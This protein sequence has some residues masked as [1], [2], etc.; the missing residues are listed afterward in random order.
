M[1]AK[2]KR[3][4]LCAAAAVLLF[5]LACSAQVT[6]SPTPEPAPTG[7][8]YTV[9]SITTIN[10]PYV[11]SMDWS[12]T[13]NL[14]AFGKLDLQDRYYDVYVM[15]PDGTNEKCLTCGKP[16][17][18]QKHNGNPAWHP[19]GDYIVFTAENPDNPVE[20][21]R[22]AVP[23][24]GFHCA[25][26]LM[27]SD[28]K[29]F[30]QL[31][32]YSTERPIK[33][34]IHP[35]FSHDGTRLLWAERV[36]SGNNLGGGWVLKIADF[37]DSDGAPHLEN[38]ET[39]TPGEQDCFYE[40]HAFSND[41]RRILFSGNL[42]SG[43]T[44]Y[45]MDI[46]EFDLE[47]GELVRLTTSDDEWDEHAHYSPDGTKIAWMSSTGFDIDWDVVEEGDHFDYLMTELWIMDADGSHPQR[48]TH[49]NDPD[50]PDYLGKTIVS[51]SSWGPDGRSLAVLVAYETERSGLNSK[52]VLV[53]LDNSE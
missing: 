40:G 16:G 15:E 38:V 39:L 53:E 11:K 7:S 25:L 17:V 42:V 19:S 32:E 27:T 52:I 51:D 21:D 49:F 28:G 36:A 37:V 9:A 13:K 2:N 22:Y 50:H 4:K 20:H 34:V 31:T 10:E 1:I 12:H 24:S 48:L 5:C 41:D 3:L 6:P 29:D 18:P 35:Q 14:I 8:T 26:W 44:P 45:G 33:G 46:Y 23:G 30:Y 47:S 43:Q